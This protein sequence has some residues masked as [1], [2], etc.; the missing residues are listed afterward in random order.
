MPQI[1]EVPGMGQVEFP[2]GMSDGD[3]SAAIKKTLAAQ[4]KPNPAKDFGG[5]PLRPFGIDTGVTLPDS[6]SNSFA[7]LGKAGTDLVRGLG[8]MTGFVSRADADA[9]KKADAPLMATTAGKV[10]NFIGNVIPAAATSFIPGANTYTGATLIGAGLG[11]LQP[12]GT[13]DSRLLN[14]GVG[15]GAG[16][17]GQYLGNK[18][19]AAIENRLSNR[20][21]AL[22]AEQSRNA[23]RD[24]TVRDALDAGFVLPPSQS[25]TAGRVGRTLE[26]LSGKITTAQ[27]ASVKNQEVTN[28]L[29]REALGLPPDVA[30][31]EQALKQVRAAAGK[32][33]EA[34]KQIQRPVTA[35]AT[36]VNEITSLGREWQSAAQRFPNLVKN[37]GI[38][39]LITD[40]N[41][42]AVKPEEAVTLIKKLRFD[43]KANMRA[44]DDPAKQALG[45]AQLEATK[46]LE[47][48]LERKLGANPANAD[49]VKNMRDARALIAK[50]YAV[51]DALNPG[52]GNVLARKLDPETTTGGLRTA[53]RFGAAFPK[54]NQSVEAM[55]SLPQVSPL[56]FAVGTLGASAGS[57]L[58]LALPLARM[59]SRYGVLSGPG[60]RAFVGA[61]NY[62]PGLLYTVPPA[63]LNE[64]TLPPAVLGGLLT[65]GAQQ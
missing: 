40:L 35:D 5:I 61:P 19:G 54:A 53:S 48:L 63:L 33:Y 52:T 49:L 25:P 3:I 42:S 50:S 20:T 29:A 64:R 21:A 13:E 1:I 30:L 22:T 46:A 45:R 55:G 16:L 26:G 58:G 34:V 38:D 28:A 18:V 2:D 12:V 23:V 17:A 10:G 9:T 15:A 43:G 24:T 57:P 14:M 4:S 59:A 32:S 31:S 41:V 37:D 62:A 44:A 8:Q 39:S 56:D 51:E 27:N 65:Y 11:A 7:G 36:Y 60:Q 6:L 47:G